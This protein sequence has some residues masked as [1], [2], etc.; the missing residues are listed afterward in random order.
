M[1]EIGFELSQ[2]AQS[3]SPH[4]SVSVVKMRIAGQKGEKWTNMKSKIN[5][6]KLPEDEP[7]PKFY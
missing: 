7:S 1:K 4:N 3:L 2:L 5:H 6:R